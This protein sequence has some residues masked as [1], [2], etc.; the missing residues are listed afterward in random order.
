MVSLDLFVL[1]KPTPPV[2]D[3]AMLTRY[4]VGELT[5]RDDGTV[6]VTV[7]V[8]P[9]TLAKPD[10]VVDTLGP[11]PTVTGTKDTVT[12]L[13]DI[14]PAGNPPPVTRTDCTLGSAAVGIVEADSVTC[15][16]TLPAPNSK[17]PKTRQNVN[18]VGLFPNAATTLRA[19][20]M[21]ED[22]MVPD[23]VVLS[24]AGDLYEHSIRAGTR[25]I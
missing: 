20:A 18:T 13:A 24:V 3:P 7:A 10:A 22:V 12:L 25:M 19:I 23:L 6:N 17:E 11:A 16:G 9:A 1:L 8:V 14:V 15:A 2:V 21:L 4:A 5:V